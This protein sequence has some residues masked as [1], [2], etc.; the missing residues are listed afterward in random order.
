VFYDVVKT[1]GLKKKLLEFITELNFLD[2]KETLYFE[3]TMKT[4]SNVGLFHSSEVTEGGVKVIRKL[5]DLPK[6][7]IFPAVDL[8]RIFLLHPNS[9][10]AY[11]Q[12]DN[13]SEYFAILNAILENSNS[14]KAAHMLALRCYSNMFKQQ[15]SH[16]AV[17]R[18]RERIMASVSPFLYSEDKNVR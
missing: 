6:D 17:M 10:E 11:N 8:Y 16:F 3:A 7:K 15:S 5:L 18:R 1:D 14:P 4:L 2:E 12:S 9:A 13:G